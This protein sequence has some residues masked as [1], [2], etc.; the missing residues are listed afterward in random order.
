M[1]HTLPILLLV[2]LL[3]Y[4]I[5]RQRQ[6]LHELYNIV[7]DLERRLDELEKI[8]LTHDKIHTN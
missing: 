4:L 6:Y 8:I 3:A 1:L 5:L 2:V 7:H